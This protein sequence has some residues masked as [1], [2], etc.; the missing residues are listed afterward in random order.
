MKRQAE[1]LVPD[2]GKNHRFIIFLSPGAIAPPLSLSFLLPSLSH[3][4][5]HTSFSII[6]A[7][8]YPAVRLLERRLFSLSL[9]LP[10]SRLPL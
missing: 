8:I 9:S 4:F 10:D 6:A 1:L 2:S 5:L 3:S 7:S